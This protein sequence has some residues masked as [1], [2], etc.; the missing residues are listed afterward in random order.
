MIVARSEHPQWTSNAYLVA[1][2]PGGHGVLID[3]N[4]ESAPLLDRIERDRITITHQLVTHGHGDHVVGVED[5]ARRFGLPLLRWP[6]LSDRRELTSC[7]LRIRALYT[8]GHRDD[9]LPLELH[10]CGGFT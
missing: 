8:L 4:G 3:G 9:H 2:G 6:H 10:G 7:D 5:M 1:D